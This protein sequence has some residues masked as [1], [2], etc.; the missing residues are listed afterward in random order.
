MGAGTGAAGGDGVGGGGGGG[1]HGRSS[2]SR[3]CFVHSLAGRSV[4]AARASVCSKFQL[5]ARNH[6][7]V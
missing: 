1:L 5:A 3:A 2:A 4:V 6:C 7:H